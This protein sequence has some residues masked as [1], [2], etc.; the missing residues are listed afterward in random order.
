MISQVQVPVSVFQIPYQRATEIAKLLLSSGAN[1]EIIEYK[2]GCSALHYA[3]AENNQ[4]ICKLLI[5]HGANPGL[6]C[7]QGFSPEAYARAS[8]HNEL[9]D[10]LHRIQHHRYPGQKKRTQQN[11]QGWCKMQDATTQRC[12]YYNRL[13]KESTWDRPAVMSTHIDAAP[14][15]L[16]RK[17]S[18]TSDADKE[19]RFKAESEREALQRQ[20]MIVQKRLYKAQIRAD[21]E[22]KQAAQMARVAQEAD[23]R[24]AQ[25]LAALKA[26]PSAALNESDPDALQAHLA[27]LTAQ[28]EAAKQQELDRLRESYERQREEERNDL[29][30]QRHEERERYH[31]E[32]EI[33][34]QEM[35]RLEHQLAREVKEKRRYYNEVEDLKGS[36]RVCARV[37]PLCAEDQRQ[38]LSEAV[39]VFGNNIKVTHERKDKSG[40][41][42]TSKTW[43]FDK[44]L[45]P[46]RTQ[47]DVF[48]DTERLVQSAL[49][50]YNVC[51]F[52][53]GQTGAGKTF[54]M[55]GTPEHPGILPRAA[56]TLFATMQTQ[57]EL[58]DFTVELY[59][60][61]LHLDTLV[62]LLQEPSSPRSEDIAPN[63]SRRKALAVKKDQFGVVYVENIT[64]VPIESEA[65][66]INRVRVGVARRAT[67][68]TRMN[69]L[70]SRSH[71]IISI[72]VKGESKVS[73][74]VTSG[75]MTLVDLAGSER[76]EKSGAVGQTFKEATSINKALSALGEVI[77]AL[78]TN[79]KH[80]PYRNNPLTQLMSD[81]I[82]GNAKT[83]MIV[84]VSA[85]ASNAAETMASLNF[86]AR[87]KSIKNAATKGFE[88]RELALL[89]KEIAKLRA[90]NKV[91]PPTKVSQGALAHS[92]GL[93]VK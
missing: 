4:Q 92:R 36:I 6:R 22:S 37:R 38:G 90:A 71:L 43:T 58:M 17:S 40:S 77:N 16:P 66:L 79:A 56:S 27:R 83:L 78:S 73:G 85:A 15:A 33:R 87:C 50:G 8:G 68:S 76:A 20:L 86:A 51:I 18:S 29:E 23:A 82:G 75:K 11:D 24:F 49:D 48:E 5:Q 63:S 45:G 46:Q 32:L 26:N 28:F 13:T 54:T 35:Q 7:S 30:R 89:R 10:L 91:T 65:E 53:Y 64:I 42:S 55:T 52:A 61:E 93:A 2:A 39:E 59:M 47:N 34:M 41:K 44:A 31:Q 84:N 81:S 69:D 21:Q 3:A 1:P 70:S 62:D 25:E 12:F 60:C 9:A 80:I 88:T 67:D 14:H 19:A 74:E 72:T 57:R